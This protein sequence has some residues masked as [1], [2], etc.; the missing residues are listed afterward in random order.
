MQHWCKPAA[1]KSGLECVCVNDHYFAVLVL[2]GSRHSW[3]NMSTVWPLH[4]KWRSKQS[5][6]SASY[7]A[8]NLNI[9]LWKLLGWFR[10]PHLWASGDWQLHH[11]KVPTR[12]SHLVQRLLAKHQITQV[13]QPLYNPD[14]VPC[15]FWLFPKLKSPLKGKR[16]QTIDEIQE[17]TMGQLMA[18]PTQDFTECFGQWKRH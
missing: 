4:S 2:G 8:L 6:E 11:D 10:R 1:K 18:I 15:D 13:T 14:L 16:F 17:H 5:K 3:L 9:L 12:K 7:F